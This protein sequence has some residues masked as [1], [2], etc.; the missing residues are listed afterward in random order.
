M[1][2]IAAA[3]TN[4]RDATPDVPRLNVPATRSASSAPLVTLPFARHGDVLLSLDQVVAGVGP[5]GREGNTPSSLLPH[6]AA[7]VAEVLN[8][9]HGAAHR[10]AAYAVAEARQTPKAS[11][12]CLGP[13]P[14]VLPSGARR[15]QK[16]VA[17][18]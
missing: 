1:G 11:T 7:V 17:L 6:P 2:V 5:V 15:V 16:V 8:V 13:V 3:S 9:L 4:A 10:T 14:T 12:S 18:V